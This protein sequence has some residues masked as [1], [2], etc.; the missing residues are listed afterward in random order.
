MM[1]ASRA[2]CSGSPLAS[3]PCLI[4]RRAVAVIVISPRAS[5]SRA[6]TGLS[7][8]STIRAL[9]FSSRCDSTG[10]RFDRALTATLLLSLREIKR[11]TLERDRQIDAFQLDVLRHL[12][13]AG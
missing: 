4:K 12:Q 10:A 5:A 6:V 2:A 8:T 3:A 13:R 11:Q 1:P 7:P 9:P